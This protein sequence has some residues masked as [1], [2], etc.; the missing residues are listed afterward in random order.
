MAIR[1]RPL[2]LTVAA[3]L[4]SAALAYDGY[5]ELFASVPNVHVPRVAFAYNQWGQATVSAV[6]NTPTLAS[7]GGLAGGGVALLAALWIL[8]SAL[9]RRWPA[10]R[11]LGW[12]VAGG[13]ALAGLAWLIGVSDFIANAFRG[14]G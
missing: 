12:T 13:L 4:L 14:V 8:G 2:L 10:P 11:Q 6:L 7:A 3:A 1:T 9:A 5:Y